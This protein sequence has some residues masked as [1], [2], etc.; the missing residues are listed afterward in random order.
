MLVRI[1]GIV[2]IDFNISN[3]RN[4]FIITYGIHRSGI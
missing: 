3:E 4:I 1:D 2:L